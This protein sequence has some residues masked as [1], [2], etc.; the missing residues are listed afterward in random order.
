MER[1]WIELPSG[2][3]ATAC[4]LISLTACSGGL[5]EAKH[6]SSQD[7]VVLS[8]TSQTGGTIDGTWDERDSEGRKV[9]GDL[10]IPSPRILA[11]AVFFCGPTFVTIDTSWTHTSYVSFPS[12]KGDGQSNLAIV[13]CVQNHVGFAF[14]AGLGPEPKPGE[15]FEL[16]YTP[17]SSLHSKRQFPSP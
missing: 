17:F 15:T 13:R 6:D 4:S 9:L 5:T 16:D 3:L 1:R 14:S 11:D 8:I 12:A 2:I 7:Y 10:T